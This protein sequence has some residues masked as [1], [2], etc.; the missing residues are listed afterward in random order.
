MTNP[1]EEEVEEVREEIVPGVARALSP[2]ARRILAMNPGPRT[3]L[4]TNTYMV[5]IDEI[6][7]IDPGPNDQ[8]HLDSIIGCGSVA[9]SSKM[10]ISEIRVAK[11][12][13]DICTACKDV[14]G[15]LDS[16]LNNPTD[17]SAIETEI[18]KLC[19]SAIASL[20]DTLIGT[21]GGKLL[22]WVAKELDPTTVCSAIDAC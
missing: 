20:C 8:G 11:P 5:G 3:G 7:V 6:A 12:E 9:H 18:E 13:I 17:Q 14:L 1:V 16:I 19:P 15:E 21:E 4:G 2:M 10:S 22:D